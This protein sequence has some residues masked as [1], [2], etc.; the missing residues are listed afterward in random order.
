MARHTAL[1][2]ETDEGRDHGKV[3]FLTE[4]SATQAEEWATRVLFALMATNIE[5]PPGFQHLGIAGVAEVGMNA[6]GKIPYAE[7]APLLAMMME[8]IEFVP[9]PTTNP[10]VKRSLVREGINPDIEEVMTA[11]HLKREF[12]KLNMGFFVAAVKFFLP[13]EETSASNTPQQSL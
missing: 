10:N 9:K 5:L 6:I 7:A 3:F 4:M 13:E 12:W 2:T 1:F 8:G 11:V